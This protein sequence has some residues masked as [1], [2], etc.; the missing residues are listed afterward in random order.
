M[1]TITHNQREYTVLEEYDE[2]ITAY[3]AI[4]ETNHIET[5]D[6]W[7]PDTESEY[8]N[9]TMIHIPRVMKIVDHMKSILEQEAQE[10][11]C[12]LNWEHNRVVEGVEVA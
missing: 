3:R 7:L 10:Q 6:I 11:Q 9:V 12:V 1:K 2:R 4:P 5:I 8:I